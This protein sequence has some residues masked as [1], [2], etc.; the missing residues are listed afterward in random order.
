MGVLFGGFVLRGSSIYPA[1]FF[2]GAWNLAGFL[3]LTHSGV[4]GT[5]SSWMMLSLF[6]LPLAVY[7]LFLLRGLTQ[8]QVHSGH[9][10][11]IE[12]SAR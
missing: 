2:H 4:E 10:L 8:S 12:S 7:G 11:G 3:N 9:G 1:A 5:A 6:T